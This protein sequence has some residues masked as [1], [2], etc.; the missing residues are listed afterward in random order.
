MG[1]EVKEKGPE[2]NFPS[3]HKE[4]WTRSGRGGLDLLI[5]TIWAVIAA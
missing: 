4:G 2:Y 1:E 5:G 3:F